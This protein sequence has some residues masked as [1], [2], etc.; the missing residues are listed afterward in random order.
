MMIRSTV[1]LVG[2]AALAAVDVSAQE[3]D[4]RSLVDP[5]RAAAAAIIAG[6]NRPDTL[7]GLL[8]AQRSLPPGVARPTR[9]WDMMQLAFLRRNDDREKSID[10]AKR[11]V[12]CYEG[13]EAQ[14]PPGSDPGDQLAVEQPQAPSIGS[15]TTADRFRGIRETPAR[16]LEDGRPSSPP[17]ATRGDAPMPSAEPANTQRARS[18]LKT[19]TDLQG[20]GQAAAALAKL[21]EAIRLDPTFASAYY[22]RGSLRAEQQQYDGA[23]ADFENAILY[24]PSAPGAYNNIAR[25]HYFRGDKA[26]AFEMLDRSLAKNSQS[27]HAYMMRGVLFV[28]MGKLEEGEGDLG[29]GER[30][31]A[32][33]KAQ[34][35]PE[36]ERARRSPPQQLIS[37]PELSGKTLNDAALL[38]IAEQDRKAAFILDAVLAKDPGNADAFLERAKARYNL[39]EFAAAQS[40]V[41]Q[42]V[43]LKPENA[44]AHRILG[45]CLI[46]WGKGDEA[47]KEYSRAIE[48]EP[49]SAMAYVDRSA[50]TFL[51]HPNL[52]GTALRDLQAALKADPRNPYAWYNMAGY[53]P[54]N[55][56]NPKPDWDFQIYH[57]SKAIEYKDDFA[58]AYGARGVAYLAKYLDAEEPRLKEQGMKDIQKALQL[59][60]EL[61]A[62]LDV[63]VE[64][65]KKIS[66]TADYLKQMMH[67]IYSPTLYKPHSG[68][69]NRGP[70]CPMGSGGAAASCKAGDNMAYDRYQSGAATGGDKKRYGDY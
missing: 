20:A 52:Q 12:A 48:L 51:F 23:I 18:A 7:D 35:G 36:I 46:V 60:P 53:Y 17:A 61:K 30:L 59:K 27:A 38:V 63:M 42:A 10:Q 64:D 50:A 6:G 13:G 68:T 28:Q 14:L 16:P 8:A 29:Y 54:A 9:C 4:L 57:Y 47:I 66:A 34:Y 62:T 65:L 37:Y 67:E 45:R 19:A 33:L 5:A 26:K 1:L 22:Q 55:F 24:E 32:G 44:E 15:G 58:G 69:G 11:A 3:S 21:D 41:S 56:S 49:G 25:I 39:R 70:S 40:D 31:Q 2:L 43:R